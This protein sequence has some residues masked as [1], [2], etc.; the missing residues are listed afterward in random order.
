MK[1]SLL[2]LFTL[3]SFSTVIGQ[4]NTCFTANPFCS[5]DQ[6][7]FPSA[8]SGSAPSGP[9]YGC[10]S[11]RPR[12]IWYYM[13]IG[14]AGTIDILLQQRTGPNGTGSQRDVDFAMWGPFSSLQAG[15]NA[16]MA[17]GLPPIQCSY[18]SS[19]S[20][21]IGIGVSGGAGSGYSTPP[22]AQVGEV[23]IVLLTN[24]AGGTNYISFNQTGG[25]GSADCSIVEPCVIDNFTV[26]V[27]ACAPQTANYSVNGSISISNPPSTGQ[28]IVED[29]NG[30]QTIVASAPFDL[31][32]YSYSLSGLVAN[33]TACSV[34]A[35]FSGNDMCS[36][37]LT[38]NAPSCSGCS[39]SD[40]TA[41][42]GVCATD[43][44][45]AVSGAITFT[46]PPSSGTL[47][48][49]TSCGGTQSFSAPFTSPTNYTIGGLTAD[50]S[51]C[52]VT[53]QFSAVTGCQSTTPITAPT[54]IMSSFDPITVCIGETPPDL[55]S[56]SS[57]GILGTWNVSSINTSAVGSTNYTFTPDANECAGIGILT[58]TVEDLP[59]A[60]AGGLATITCESP[61]V[62][63]YGSS[64]T[65]GVSY[66]WTGPGIVSGGTTSTPTVNQ[67][68]TYTLTVTSPGGCTNT[69]LVSVIDD[70]NNLPVSIENPQT[71]TCIQTSI[72]LNGS[73]SVAGL[74]YSWTGPG[75][76]SGANTPTP[77]VNLPGTYTLTATHPSNG[78]EGTSSVVVTEDVSPFIVDAGNSQVITCAENSIQLNGSASIPNVNY[79]WSGPG[80]ISGPTTPNPIV[81]QVGVYTLTVTNPLNGCTS[82]A[83]VSVISNIIPPISD[84][85][86]DTLIG[87]QGLIVNFTATVDSSLWNYE[88]N[89]GNGTSG[90]GSTVSNQYNSSGCYAVTLKVTD[91]NNGCVNTTT[92]TD[93][94]CIIANPTAA[95]LGQ[96]HT[97]FVDGE[98]L[99]NFKNNSTNANGYT[100]VFI[101]GSEQ[102]VENASFDF[103][104][105]AAGSY[106]VYLYVS[107][108]SL[109]FD[110][111]SILIRIKE[112]IIFYVPNT[113]TPDGDEFNQSFRP[114]ITSGIDIYNFTFKIY[115]RWGEVIW[116][117]KDPSVGWDG[118][119]NSRPIQQGTYTWSME[120]KLTD[121]D[122]H[123]QVHGHLNL[124]R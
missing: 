104:G 107:N 18:S 80:I 6:Y 51:V 119:Y 50:G 33:G 40:L 20:E 76:V 83:D 68:G 99:V 49:T 106:P 111:T 29:C 17:G 109:C 113:F 117:S 14:V 48:V 85:I 86:A 26:N 66:S 4:T 103:K 9:S 30:N 22:A 42:V 46:N 123:I 31:G 54:Y 116:E 70:I 53:A 5:S 1:K 87:C 39:M 25:T 65:P 41:N 77:T 37:V 67:T 74:N 63:L 81:N 57:E 112:D 2:L 92:P 122:D 121:V 61:T 27:S 82:S 91:S 108:E 10:L 100:W 79:S 13:E 75:I 8:S 64:S 35:Y 102:Y 7:N 11:S 90:V 45:Y 120:F 62:Q 89:F 52:N 44:T 110:S 69:S 96:P 98:S 101:D 19:Y 36:A 97:L 71:L 93:S 88:W 72:Q 78:C 84:F 73:S 118:T 12:P 58:V 23:Y 28:L 38:Y 55:P 3:L 15:C 105:Y 115:N 16:I 21:D 124:I 47:V 43:G 32:S 114:I 24:Y 95:F 34:E 56:G 60:N 59:N 94:I